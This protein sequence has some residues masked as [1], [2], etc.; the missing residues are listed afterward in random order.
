MVSRELLALGTV[1]PVRPARLPFVN[2]PLARAGPPSFFDVLPIAVHAQDLY[3]A[4]YGAVDA[5]THLLSRLARVVIATPIRVDAIDAGSAVVRATEDV[6]SAVWPLCV[7]APPVHATGL[8]WEKVFNGAVVLPFHAVAT[9]RR[10]ASVKVHLD[11][12]GCLG[13][14]APPLVARACVN[15]HPAIGLLDAERAVGHLDAACARI[16]VNV[17]ASGIARRL[18]HFYF[19][20]H[21]F[22]NATLDTTRTQKLQMFTNAHSGTAQSVCDTLGTP[23]GSRRRHTWSRRRGAC[24]AGTW[25]PCGCPCR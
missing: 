15:A 10:R 18:G 22:T 1:G 25:C 16:C 20:A 24:T 2:A 11:A 13:A 19:C 17:C 4:S 21:T 3:G 14:D 9:L 12:V 23:R 7:E 6:N 5:R 8:A